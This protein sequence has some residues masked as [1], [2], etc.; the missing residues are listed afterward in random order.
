MSSDVQPGDVK[1]WYIK[2]YDFFGELNT[3]AMEFVKQT[4]SMHTYNSD[5]V[6]YLGGQEDNIYLLKSGQVK[7]SRIREDGD[8]IIQDVLRPGEIFGSLPMMQEFEN[9]NDTEHAQ[10]AGKVVVCIIH[11]KDFE[12]L[13]EMHPK[14]HQRL[15]KWY[16]LR[17]RRFEERLNE[18]IFKDVKK[19][20][21]GF[22][23]RY[24]KDFGKER[25]DYYEVK[26]M[27][28][29]EE[30]GLLTGAARQTVT[31]MLNKF[32]EEGLLEFDR[33]CWKIKKINDLK[34]LA[35]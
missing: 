24:A 34:K 26:P 1:F 15:S 14:L 31:S 18:L 22:L 29:H 28:T 9:G 12:K 6:I 19:R 35:S 23:L 10:A 8:E 4:T 16:G 25:E 33:K 13:L 5:D 17:M 30:I 21:A 27:L 7:I 20:I 32:K 3:K 2:H 11:K